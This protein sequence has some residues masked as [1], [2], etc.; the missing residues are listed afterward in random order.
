MKPQ[1]LS[2]YQKVMFLT[3]P[4]EYLLPPLVGETISK[5]KQHPYFRPNTKA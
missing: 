3:S 2:N 5:A 4:R 1:C